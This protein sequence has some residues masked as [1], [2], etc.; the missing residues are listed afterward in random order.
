M[1]GLFGLTTLGYSL[2]RFAP[3]SPLNRNL[4][5]WWRALPLTM[6]GVI[7]HDLS[8]HYP[9]TLSNMAGGTATSG[10]G[11]TMRPGGHGE[12]RW[13]GLDDQG[14]AGPILALDGASAVT[15]ALWANQR[16]LDVRGYFWNKL[17][18]SLFQ[19]SIE[20]FDDG[21]L[22]VEVNNGA[23][24]YG[25]FDYSTAVTAGQWWHL[26]VVFDGSGAANADRLK[27]Y[28]DGRPQTLSFA[29]TIGNTWPDLGNTPT[30][31][32]CSS[33]G[34]SL[35]SG[36][37]DD[38][39]VQ[40][41]AL[42]ATD[43]RALYQASRAGY[44]S[45]LRWTTPWGLVPLPAFVD[46]DAIPSGI[47]VLWN[48]TAASIPSG[49][50]RETALDCRYPR[51]A[52]AGADGG[53]TGGS[54]THSHTTT[55]HSH[56]T[57][58]THLV[59][60]TTGTGGTAS[61]RDT[62]TTNPPH[63]HTHASNPNA[64]NPATT[65][66]TEAP[67]TDA[68]NH[69]PAYVE[70]LF[71]RSL[72]VTHGFP[73][74]TISL[75][76]DSAAAPSGWNLCDG[77]AGRPDY[78]STFPKGAAAA[79]NPGATGGGSTT[80]THT[81]AS[82]THGGTYSH[83]HPGV[84]S[85]QRSEA[86]VS[87]T[88]SGGAA[89]VA[90]GAHTHALTFGTTAPAITAQTDSASSTA[91]VEP[92]YWV[93]A[94]IQNISGTL[95][96]TNG[97]I[98]LWLGSAASIPANWALC[99]GANGTPDLR[100]LFVKGAATLGGIGGSGGSTTA[101][102]HTATG[103]THSIASHA[104]TVTGGTGASE[105]RTAGATNTPPDTHTHTWP[106]TTAASLTSG[107]TT[108]TIADVADTLPPYVSV[109][110]L[111]WQRLG[112]VVNF[113]ASL[114]GT[115]TT[116]TSLITT[117]R[118]IP[119]NVLGASTTRVPTAT[120]LR[121][122][123][124]SLAGASLT[125][126]AQAGV[127]PTLHALTAAPLGSSVTPAALVT[128]TLGFA[129]G[130]TNFAAT[131]SV[132]IPGSEH[133]LATSDLLIQVYD[134]G[135]PY[136]AQ[137]QGQVSIDPS[138]FTITAS[139]AEAQSGALLASATVHPSSS[140]T[141]SNALQVSFP[142]SGHLFSTPNLLVSVYDA[143]GV[144]LPAAIRVHQTTYEVLVDFAAP[145]S[146]RVVVASAIPAGAPANSGQTFSAALSVTLLGTTHGRGTD[147][148]VQTYDNGTPR[149][150]VAGAVVVHPVS[151]D[152]TVT[153]GTAQSGRLVVGGQAVA[154]VRQLSASLLGTSTTPAT[155]LTTVRVLPAALVSTSTT[156]AALLTILRN[157]TGA[158]TGVSTTPA[159]DAILLTLRALSAVVTGL[160]TTPASEG[161]QVRGL[162]ATLVAASTTPLAVSAVL[163]PLTAA[164]SG[165]S[166][167][168]APTISLVAVRDLT[169]TLAGSSPTP[170][171]DAVMLRALTATLTASSTTPGAD[172]LLL[173][174]RQLVASLSGASTTPLAVS[175]VLRPQSALLA[176]ASV[177]RV[178]T[179]YLTGVRALNASPSGASVTQDSLVLTLRRLSAQ[180]VGASA[181]QDAVVTTPRPL[182][183]A[184]SGVSVT[185]PSDSALVRTLIAAL[186]SASV[187]P[188]AAVSLLT[189]RQ[190]TA[191][192][193]GL[194]TT[195]ASDSAVQRLLSTQ[196]T[197]TSVTP[198]A[199]VTL[200]RALSAA[201]SGVS[202]TPASLATL[203]HALLAVLSG[204]SVTQDSTVVLTGLRELTAN[205]VGAATTPASLSTQQRGLTSVL[206]GSST[207]PAALATT[208]RPLSAVLLGASTT[209]PGLLINTAVLTSA[210]LGTSLTPPA[211][212]TM[213]R[214]LGA[215][216]QGQS[217]TPASL[218]QH[219]RLLT[220]APGGASVTPESL[221]V[222]VHQLTSLLAGTSITPVSERTL[223]RTL[224][225]LLIGTTLSPP[226]LLTTQRPLAAD[227]VASSVTPE[228]TVIPN[229]GE[230]ACKAALVGVSVTQGGRF[231]LLPRERTTTVPP[232]QR[233][234]SVARA[235]SRV[236]VVS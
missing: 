135:T 206:L 54:A 151:G 173:T 9:I 184:L 108:P 5:A 104:H 59:P 14:N 58:H 53:S 222:L 218:V 158:L 215:T 20:T 163:R 145:Q 198:S 217:L 125:Q 165:A 74:S 24:S 157:V 191:A 65:T 195:P 224:V 220:A 228:T 13:D 99:D 205:L 92:P 29:G 76:A 78:R 236:T 50:T 180:V 81:V 70:T 197:G 137:V 143:A 88:I 176:G 120:L 34:S 227:L 27:I 142:A 63:V 72:G 230:M 18:S 223:A 64:P 127:V 189:G 190:L 30:L 225:A 105:S 40:T 46:P 66:D 175:A 122:L 196:A 7:W 233:Q 119:A 203:Q 37:L 201:P 31:I 69:E 172:A 71:L 115:S 91:L 140:L 149:L 116:P 207:T 2:P 231:V 23:A 181:T 90:T 83:T 204:Q 22:Y 67:S 131:Q 210:P 202:V 106:D 229:S 164:P 3:Q 130:R 56:T 179:I 39:R 117:L 79:G 62:G 25:F 93:L 85:T 41:R 19:T 129:Q 109:L 128:L 132:V 208:L 111:Q 186:S 144:R 153:F 192:L 185:P 28:I 156:P 123:S 51:G 136:A 121:S 193:Q 86:L 75:W 214:T 182:S 103:H 167:T 161:T 168:R 126:D 148:L 154:G 162:L 234:T 226:T 199:L 221:G 174:L 42:S 21:F 1:A 10:W 73:A 219:L 68:V 94:Y 97:V 36:M 100:T 213:A 77:V 43:V 44:P 45:M 60:N 216:L 4:L 82:H 95:Q 166:V 112:P 133:A 209:P 177:T 138:T 187:T 139:F 169:A 57:A 152:V 147:V 194:S 15:I 48:G 211:L 107:S 212:T 232:R 12:L 38:L 96:Q 114:L 235:R 159:A 16:V 183:S 17:V 89:N 98:A 113:T 26:C 6:G 178:P 118:A 80:H 188:A 102:G 160:S 200:A 11:S 124:S 32:G 150:Q 101:H 84:T 49:W 110:F 171:A 35:F 155:L 141:F 55:T 47:T 61:A 146:G 52:A 87:G 33:G 134:S 170:A 8:G